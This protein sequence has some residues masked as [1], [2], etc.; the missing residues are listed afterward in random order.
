MDKGSNSFDIV[1]EPSHC[2]RPNSVYVPAAVTF[3]IDICKLRGRAGQNRMMQ[4]PSEPQSQR[5]F[6]RIGLPIFAD[7]GNR[8]TRFIVSSKPVLQSRR[9]GGPECVA[10]LRLFDEVVDN[11]RFTKQSG[12]SP[13][14]AHGDTLAASDAE[15]GDTFFHVTIFHRR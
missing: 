12:L 9:E 2:K 8:T 15:R 7:D 5:V 13:L 1:R 6:S 4:R 3:R 11:F 10:P 14:D